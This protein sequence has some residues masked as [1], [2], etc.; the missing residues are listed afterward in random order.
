MNHWSG[1]EDHGEALFA[2]ITTA[3]DGLGQIAKERE[4]TKECGSSNGIYTKERLSSESTRCW[5]R[6]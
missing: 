5:K 1:F 4:D 2:F 3:L 6:A